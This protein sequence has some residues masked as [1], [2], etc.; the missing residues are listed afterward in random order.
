MGIKNRR[1]SWIYE[2]EQKWKE[3]HIFVNNFFR[4]EFNFEK[5][6][7]LSYWHLVQNLK[8]NSEKTVQKNEKHIL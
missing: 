6:N 3:C 5:I 8:S 4:M 7:F 1:I 2:N